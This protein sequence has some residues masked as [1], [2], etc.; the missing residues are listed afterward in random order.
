VA[1]LIVTVLGIA[2]V[3]P[4]R[5]FR[6]DLKP[7]VTVPLGV[8]AMW[9]GG[10]FFKG[11][12]MLLT[13][14]QPLLGGAFIARSLTIIG[15]GAV[16]LL[17]PN[18][19]FW[20][21]IYG[22]GVTRVML[23]AALLPPSGYYSTQF[24]IAA[25]VDG[26]AAI[27]AGEALR[28]HRDVLFR[29]ALIVVGLAMCGSGGIYWTDH[30]VLSGV[31][32]S[33]IGAAVVGIGATMLLGRRLLCGV[34][35]VLGG[36]ASAGFGLVL[37]REHSIMFAAAL[38]VLGAAVAIGGV[39]VI[40]PNEIGLRVRRCRDRLVTVRPERVELKQISELTGDHSPPAGT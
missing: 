37:W 19:P 11:G 29:W 12:V 13:E 32:V 22:Q 17:N 34:T 10:A 39:R 15:V 9:G 36:L 20:P 1:A 24:G 33:A 28:T 8:A 31:T 26:T 14:H 2:L 5:D 40:G 38:N 18:T 23:G 25:I 35:L 21:I 6:K 27:F 30:R 3:L 7:A 16:L 4:N